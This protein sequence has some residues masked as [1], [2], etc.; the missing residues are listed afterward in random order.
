MGVCT[1][2][3]H[4]WQAIAEGETPP[5]GGGLPQP[6]WAVCAE[7]VTVQGPVKT[8]RPDGMSHGRGRGQNKVC[9][10][11]IRFPSPLI[12]FIFLMWGGWV[13]RGWLGPQTS[14]GLT[15]RKGTQLQK[16]VGIKDG[17][18]VRKPGA[19]S[20]REPAV[21]FGRLSAVGSGGPR[22]G[23]GMHWKGGGTPPPPS[24][25]RPAYAQPLSP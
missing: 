9:V 19:Q 4:G 6:R 24:P 12:N 11:K 21:L 25:G 13:G 14:N 16:G 7:R 10:P 8:Q 20:Q 1:H 2:A 17:V 22:G 5:P 3:A 23:G 15:P 18:G